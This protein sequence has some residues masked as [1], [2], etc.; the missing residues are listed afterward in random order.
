MKLQ[1]RVMICAGLLALPFA[2]LAMAFGIWFGAVTFEMQR[3]LLSPDLPLPDGDRVVDHDAHHQYQREHR[4]DAD[5]SNDR[6][7]PPSRRA[8]EE[9]GA[10]DRHDGEEQARDGEPGRGAHERHGHVGKLHD[11]HRDGAQ[12]QAGEGARDELAQRVTQQ[13]VCLARYQKFLFR[14]CITIG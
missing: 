13:H 9:D 6:H 11:F 4:H 12:E 2:V 10:R 5:G 1:W 8:Q 3:M 7:Q 14:S